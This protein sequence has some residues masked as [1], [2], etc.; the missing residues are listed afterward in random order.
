MTKGVWFSSILSAAPDGSG[1]NA[2]SDVGTLLPRLS[3]SEP[4]KLLV[5]SLAAVAPGDGGDGGDDDVLVCT[6]VSPGLPLVLALVLPCS[7]SSA[8][9]ARTS[10]ACCVRKASASLTELIRPPVVAPTNDVLR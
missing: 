3:R 1:P 9:C 8:C 4:T 6:C 10:S 2:F 7:R 5:L